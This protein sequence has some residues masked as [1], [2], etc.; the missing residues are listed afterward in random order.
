ML[1]PS[2]NEKWQSRGIDNILA[3][4]F[5]NLGERKLAELI[6]L[7][8]DIYSTWIWLEDFLR[9]ILIPLKKMTNATACKYH[10]TTSLFPRLCNGSSQRECRQRWKQ[11]STSKGEG[12]FGF[13]GGEG[14]RDAI[15]AIRV[16]KERSLEYVPDLYMCFVDYEKVFDRCMY[17]DDWIWLDG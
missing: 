14:S 17:S 12:Q 1:G 10:W 9:Y 5:K 6:K 7:C 11:S 15:R 16:L 3:D 4:I 13:T 2:L 8:Q